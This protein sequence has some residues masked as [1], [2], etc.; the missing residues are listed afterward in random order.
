MVRLLDHPTVSTAVSHQCE[1]GLLTHDS[2]GAMVP[3]KKP[4]KRATTS[5]QMIDWLSTRCKG[6]HVHQHPMGGRAGPAAIYPLELITEILRGIRDTADAEQRVQESKDIDRHIHLHMQA[7]AS[8][9]D[10]LVSSL[11][12]VRREGE[13]CDQ[14]AGRRTKL[15]MADGTT[16]SINLNNH[17]RSHYLDEYTNE[18]LPME[19]IKDA[20]WVELDYF[21]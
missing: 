17:F 9:G 7:D 4:T 11:N 6:G 5:Q 16:R 2:S 13:L 21:L 10:R 12:V 3:A 20:I 18:E 15:R 8:M 14:N 1:Y 19:H